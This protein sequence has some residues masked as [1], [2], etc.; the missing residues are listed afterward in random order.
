MSQTSGR[1]QPLVSL[2]NLQSRLFNNTLEGIP[3]DKESRRPGDAN[4]HAQW[5]AG[6]LVSTRYFIGSLIGLREEEPHPEFFAQGKGIDDTLTYPTLEQSKKDWK[7]ITEKIGKRLSEVS[8]EDLSKEAPFPN[9][10]GDNSVGGMLDFLTHHEAYHI[11]QL[12]YLRKYLGNEA[13]KY[14]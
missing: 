3:G 10:T 5:L 7:V 9:P 14:D 2:F 13:M 6:H 8:D 12:G 4:N 11:G 1:I